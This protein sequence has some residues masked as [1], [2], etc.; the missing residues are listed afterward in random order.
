M[1]V[2][3]SEMSHLKCL[4]AP[5]GDPDV[6]PVPDLLLVQQDHGGRGGV[7]GGETVPGDEGVLAD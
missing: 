3:L 7:L 4:V 5:D 6:V 2:L 1:S